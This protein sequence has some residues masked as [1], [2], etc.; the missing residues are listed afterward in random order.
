MRNSTKILTASLTSALMGLG[1]FAS[2]AFGAPAEKAMSGR[3]A[4]LADIQKAFGF[5]PG[6]FEAMPAS[7]LPGTWDEMKGL[8]M[9]PATA[10]SG[11]SKELIG[12]GVAAQIPC[13]YCVE[14]HTE[15]AKLNGASD[16]EIGEAVAA[17]AVARHW[18]AF[19]QGIGVDEG[20]YRGEIDRLVKVAKKGGQAAPDYLK[21]FPEAGRAGAV[22]VMQ[23]LGASS[24]V[25]A[26]DKQ[27][28]SLAVAAQ[29][30]SQS[31]IY[32]YTEF[33]KLAGATEAEINEALAMSAFT[34][35]A[36]TLLNGL[37]IDKNQFRADISRL[38]KGAREAAAKGGKS[39]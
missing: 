22:R 3:A 35:H 13:T 1:A 32:A 21:R 36:S 2:A 37:Q 25:S 33:A 31:C 6:F 18:S 8:Q 26:K 28:I 30:P 19:T 5:V 34:R 16:E 7:V 29:I 14:A 12:L 9:N 10:L 17:A 24:A 15:F 20:K 4:A 27:L 39:H 23:D 11:K 38:V